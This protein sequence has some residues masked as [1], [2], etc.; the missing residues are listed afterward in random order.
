MA[1]I[2]D[3]AVA[4]AA[5]VAITRASMPAFASSYVGLAVRG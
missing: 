2:T 4:M 3:R 5:V 1:L